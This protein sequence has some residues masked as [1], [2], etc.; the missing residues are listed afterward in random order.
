MKPI[1]FAVF[2]FVIFFTFD[3]MAKEDSNH[4]L[5]SY[6]QQIDAEAPTIARRLSYV[7]IYS[8]YFDKASVS[9]SLLADSLAEWSKVFARGFI[10][11]FDNGEASEILFLSRPKFVV[12]LRMSQRFW[13]S[14]DEISREVRDDLSSKMR[15]D[16]DTVSMAGNGTFVFA[17]SLFAGGVLSGAMKAFRLAR[18]VEPLAS[19]QAKIILTGAASA[20]TMTQDHADFSDL[21]ENMGSTDVNH[22]VSDADKAML[23][24]KENLRRKFILQQTQKFSNDSNFCSN[25]AELT[26]LI[27]MQNQL[28]H[29]RDVLLSDGLSIKK[30]EV[31]AETFSTL[32]ESLNF[33][34]N[35]IQSLNAAPTPAC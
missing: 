33:L 29:Y 28:Q 24:Y 11:D 22:L 34:L 8:E 12:A 27:A 9:N 17:S 13:Q 15:K 23:V 35:L 2:S 21:S 19:S 31:D 26:E 7:Y 3:S 25:Q 18:F 5:F 10:A 6:Y 1:W 14:M 20:G 4:K 30:S 32:V 16:L